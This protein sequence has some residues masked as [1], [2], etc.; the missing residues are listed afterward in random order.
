MKFVGLA[1]QKLGPNRTAKQT[2]RQTDRQTRRTH[3]NATFAD[4]K[5]LQLIITE[6]RKT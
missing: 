6:W 4:A 1:N 2:D 5:M 3:N